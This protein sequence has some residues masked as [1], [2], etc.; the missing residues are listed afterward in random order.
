MELNEV[1]PGP[2]SSADVA[3]RGDKLSEIDSAFQGVGREVTELDELLSAIVNRLVP[4][5]RDPGEQK[6]GEPVGHQ[7]QA[8]LAMRLEDLGRHVSQVTARARDL[9]ERI[10]V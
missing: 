2:Y 10:E 3:A 6:L 9:L 5:C 1:L 4:V 8:P 7:Y